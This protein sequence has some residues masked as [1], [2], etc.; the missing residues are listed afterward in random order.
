VAV[1]FSLITLIGMSVALIVGKVLKE[2]VNFKNKFIPWITLLISILTQVVE[3]AIAEAG[4]SLGNL[5][6]S[7]VGNLLFSV[8][9]QWLATTG[10]HSVAK[11]VVQK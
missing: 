4:I 5:V 6:H 7:P 3:P 9:I 10:T 8:L 1:D 11:N 2:N